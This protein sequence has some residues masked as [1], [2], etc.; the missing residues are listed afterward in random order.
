MKPGRRPSHEARH[1]P[2][3]TEETSGCSESLP[4]S[5]AGIPQRGGKASTVPELRHWPGWE[6]L[7]LESEQLPGQLGRKERAGC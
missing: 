2:A 1:P 4:Q 6:P 5:V 3:G 7:S